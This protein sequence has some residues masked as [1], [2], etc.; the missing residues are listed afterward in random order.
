MSAAYLTKWPEERVLAYFWMM[1]HADADRLALLK[2][3][4]AVAIERPADWDRA[5]QRAAATP[6]TRASAICFSCLTGDRR[7]YWHHI[8]AIQHGGSTCINNLVSICLACHAR[9]HPWLNAEQPNQERRRTGNWVRVGDMIRRMG[10]D[11]ADLNEAATEAHAESQAP[12]VP[13]V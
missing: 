10:N 1:V 5:G 7:L 8:I 3:L 9:V 13:A 6:M 11:G 4:T 2:Q 12:R